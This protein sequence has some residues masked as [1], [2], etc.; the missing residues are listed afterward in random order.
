MLQ[1]R[2]KNDRFSVCERVRWWN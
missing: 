1:L 2:F